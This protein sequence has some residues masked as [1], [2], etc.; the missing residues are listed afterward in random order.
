MIFLCL[1]LS[2]QSLSRP[3][4]IRQ[5]ELEVANRPSDIAVHRE[6]A[7]HLIET[8]SYDAGVLAAR[9]GLVLAPGDEQ[10]TLSLA[11]GLIPMGRSQEAVAALRELTPSSRNRFVLGMAYRALGEPKAARS[12]LLEAWSLGHRD[13]YLLY[14]VIEQDRALGDK[15]SGLD[16]F[17]LFWKEFPDSPWLHMLLADAHVVAGEDAAAEAEYRKALELQEA[18]PLANFHVGVLRF[19]AGDSA[20]A[21]SHFRKEIEINPQLGEPYAYLGHILRGRGKMAEALS[22]LKQAVKLDPNS[23]FALREL[24]V[25]QAEGGHLTEALATLQ[26]ASRQFPKDS[27]F[28]VQLSQVLTRLG[29]RAEAKKEAERA[30]MLLREKLGARQAEI[31]GGQRR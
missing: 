27:S 20:T 28:A 7:A 26:A 3:E 21:E 15:A 2:A 22:I 13:P 14:T 12:S 18:I 6:L 10:L 9:R 17:K 16:H 11:A 23:A 29:R 5:L 4:R 1:A 31:S 30:T 19:Q 24:A 25:A 8:R